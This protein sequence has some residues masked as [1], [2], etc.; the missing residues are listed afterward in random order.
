M[1][2][3]GRAETHQVKFLAA[4]FYI[5]IYALD[6]CTAE[7]LVVT[8]GL[9]DFHKILIYNASGT[10]IHV[11]YLRI[12]H[13]SV[14]KTDSLTASEKVAHRIFGSER[15]NERCSGCVDGIRVVML[16]LAPA[17]KNHKK[18]FSIHICYYLFSARKDTKS[19][20]LFVLI[21]MFYLIL[22]I[23]I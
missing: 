8:A 21:I 10:E 13:L 3:A 15:V 23:G 18:N 17:I 1:H 12:A 20:P 22:H 9:I 11:A 16:A 14:R 4:L 7:K 5:I 6:F 19:L 2:A